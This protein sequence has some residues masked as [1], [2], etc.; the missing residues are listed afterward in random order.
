MRFA[1]L[2][3]RPARALTLLLVAVLPFATSCGK[4]KQ[5]L[6]R[7]LGETEEFDPVWRSDSA[8]IFSDPQVL[9]R[10]IDT[11]KGAEIVPLATIGPK[12]FTP[13]RLGD[14]GWKALDLLALHNPNTLVPVKDGRSLPPVTMTRGMWGESG[15]PL[16]SIPNCQVIVPSGLAK[17]PEGVRILT[18]SARPAIAPLQFFN[19]AQMS[20]A[21]ANLSTLVTPRAG[22]PISALSHYTR[23]VRQVNNGLGK[24]PTLVVV[25]EDP[26]VLPDT[27]LL[28]G[29]RPRN[30]AMVLDYA[31]FGYRTTWI[32]ATVGNAK[33]TP[34]LAYLDH[35]DVDGDGRPE[36]LFGARGKVAPLLTM[37]LKYDGEVWLETTRYNRTRC[38]G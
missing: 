33:T 5:R 31:M 12:G 11:D 15:P 20:A 24:H 22:I 32:Y 38:Q 28:D 36:I 8:K 18:T 1:V 37:V 4:V 23:T 30:V 25:Y 17:L 14:R 6:K 3:P 7:M 2:V 10:V 13:L 16:D 21:L 26:E 19:E 34:R 27:T 29:Q 9:Y 35:V